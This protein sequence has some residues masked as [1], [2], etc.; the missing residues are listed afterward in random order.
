MLAA[1]AVREHSGNQYNQQHTT[2]AAGRAGLQGSSSTAS[3]ADLIDLAAQQ[4]VAALGALVAVLL[5]VQVR[6]R[7]R[8]KPLMCASCT[9]HC[10]V[11]DGVVGACY[12]CHATR[13]CP[14]CKQVQHLH[15]K[16][17]ACAVHMLPCSPCHCRKSPFRC[18]ATMT[19]T[20]CLHAARRCWWGRGHAAGGQAYRDEA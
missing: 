2:G 8:C 6:H 18:G 14:S 15:G 12:S 7:Q 16:Y 9:L 20:A 3:T 11:L 5:Q 10:A 17:A 19:M 13:Q 4:Q 1:V